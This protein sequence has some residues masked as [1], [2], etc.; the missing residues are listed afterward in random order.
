MSKQSTDLEQLAKSVPAK[1]LPPLQDWHPPLSGD[2]E[3]RIDRAGDWWFKGNIIGRE[4]LVKL[5]STILRL[6]DDGEY[7][8]VSPVEKWRI[9][10]EDT[11]LLAHSLTVSGQGEQQVITLTT[12]VGEI[13]NIGADHPLQMDTYP[14][15]GEPRP[16][17]TVRHGVQARLVTAA[18]YELA[19]L[20]VE[21]LIG[22]ETVVGVLSEGNFYKLTGNG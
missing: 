16:L 12:N 8:L 18:Y 17:I 13:L 6:E 14:G 21:R 11:P 3:M 5:F 22:G 4:A 7:Y 1:G 20:A 2:M 10:V 19:D 15:T 9:Q